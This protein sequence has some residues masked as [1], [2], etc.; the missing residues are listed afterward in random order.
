MEKCKN[1]AYNILI[2]S[3]LILF[4]SFFS[5]GQIYQT[6]TARSLSLGGCGL[7]LNDIGS[8]YSN[9]ALLATQN[10]LSTSCNYENDFFI[11]MLQKSALVVGLPLT[12]GVIGLGVRTYGVQ[13]FRS[14]ESTIGYGL[15]LNENFS[16]GTSLGIY[17]T[18]IQVYGSKSGMNFEV[19][20][21][22]NLSEKIKYACS[23]HLLGNSN[24]NE[25]K[26]MNVD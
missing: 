4:S 7:L 25:P 16:I 12:K 1:R 26:P 11:S 24:V 19:G 6:T 14:I 13:S 22:G 3:V 20:I 17:N 15:Q 8:F 18:S 2:V 23:I 9:P 10:Q 5:L 21:Y